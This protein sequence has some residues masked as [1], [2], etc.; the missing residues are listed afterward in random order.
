MSEYPKAKKEPVKRNR[1]REIVIFLLA[2]LLL[3][4][5]SLLIV[6]KYIVVNGSA[7]QPQYIIPEAN[8][9]V[10]DGML[11]TDNPDEILA[12]LQ[13]KVD[14]NQFAFRINANPRFTADCKNG[15]LRIENP[16]RNIYCM[17]V[18]LILD[19]TGE[20]LYASPLIKPN[21]YVEYIA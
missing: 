10:F 9:E 18:E 21:Q 19:E 16:A 8:G 2:T 7:V 17:Q 1:W 20:I 12:L 3:I 4:S 6:N 13:E 5:L 11:P 15:N 14:E